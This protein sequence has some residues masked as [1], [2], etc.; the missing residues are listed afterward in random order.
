M[1]QKNL[2]EIIRTYVFSE[3]ELYT[4]LGIEGKYIESNQYSGR[5][6]RDIEK[7]VSPD[8][9]TWYIQTSY[10]LK[11]RTKKNIHIQSKEIRTNVFSSKT[12]K[13][14]FGLEGYVT[15]IER[16]DKDSGKYT[17]TTSSEDK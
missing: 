9:E 15:C 10:P 4:T 7:G 8:V 17:I 11:G 2:T 1:P 3:K 5:S 6:G 12:L 13:E 14:L 16:E